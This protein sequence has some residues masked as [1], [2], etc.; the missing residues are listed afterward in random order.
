MNRLHVAN[1][2]GVSLLLHHHGLRLAGDLGLLRLLLRGGLHAHKGIG[3]NLNMP[4]NEVEQCLASGVFAAAVGA[5]LARPDANEGIR[6][7]LMTDG[8]QWPVPR[9]HHGVSLERPQVGVNGFR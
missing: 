6:F 1:G 8:G 7:T 5:V 2:D 4:P 9:V 3:V